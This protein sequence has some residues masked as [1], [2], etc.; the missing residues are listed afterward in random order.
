MKN[1]IDILAVIGNHEAIGEVDRS[2]RGLAIDSRLVQRDM[3][4]IALRGTQVD[5]HQ[6]IAA[7]IGEGASV[8]VCEDISGD[9]IAGITYIKVRDTR[10]LP[11]KMASAFYDYPS[12]DMKIVGVTGTN[13]KTTCTTLLYELFT[14]MGFT[15]GLIS[16]V[17]Y[18]IGHLIYDSSHTTP[19]PI[20]LQELLHE[21]KANN[22]A[23][24]FMEVSSH[25]I[26]QQRISGIEFVGGAFTN[27]SRD[28][29]D[30]HE[31]F[32]EYIY[33][34]KRF[35]DDLN[36]DAFA[37]TNKDDKQGPIMLQNTAASKHSYSVN[38]TAEFNARLLEDTFEGL[39]LSIQGRDVY[40][41]LIGKFNAYNF[42]AVYGIAIL[43]GQEKETFL[44]I[45]SG[46]NAAEGRFD[47]IISA[48]QK[49]IGIVD[50]AHTP[51]A[52][53][54]VLS[55]VD[56]VKNAG[57]S[58]IC[59]VGCGGDRDVGKRPLMAQ[60]SVK[61]ADK[62]IFTSDNPRSEDPHAIIE[63]MMQ[64]L[65]DDQKSTVFIQADR[66]EAI[67]MAAVIAQPEDVVVVA[68]KGHEKYQEINGVRKDFDDKE[69]LV[70]TF[71]DLNL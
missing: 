27:I 8:I 32:D 60:I 2:V 6:Y 50:Y 55:T 22:C 61:L 37:L 36:K 48:K 69:I 29:L 33:A 17:N 24:V 67:R 64:G 23:Y 26:D 13:G 28:H 46:L 66:K 65:S 42:M 62:S 54:N 63:D 16:T 25:A 12:R 49:I 51:D 43:L 38:G 34:K 45:L 52:L 21:M 41:R 53:E 14:K 44:P 15:C 9:P 39:H 57:S 4:Y 68:G 5:G 10:P 71:N 20:R 3:V 7:A 19:D 30:Y 70:R 18:R 40:T 56:E 47:Y 11:G 59:V 1:L 31:T 35:F 58:T